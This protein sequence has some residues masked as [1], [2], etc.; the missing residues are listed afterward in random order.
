M[1][2]RAG[3][4]H[5]SHSEDLEEMRHM[6]NKVHHYWSVLG[7]SLQAK[8]EARNA[9]SL[10]DRQNMWQEIEK[11]QQSREARE[12][13]LQMLLSHYTRAEI[14]RDAALPV[15]AEL[16][17]SDQSEAIYSS[18]STSYSGQKL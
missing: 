4:S 18:P 8:W 15:L 14:D 3:R 11:R 7:P 10:D 12:I 9:L 2:E 6:V 16:G 17:H 5:W 1:A 13:D